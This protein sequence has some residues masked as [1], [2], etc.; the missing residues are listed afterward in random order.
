MNKELNPLILIQEIDTAIIKR[1]D[2]IELI[3][4]EISR[5]KAPL[6]EA[7]RKLKLERENLESI[8]KKKRE[9]DQGLKEIADK[10][11]NSKK[12]ASEIKTNKEY[13]AHLA[14]IESIESEKYLI[15]DDILFLMEEID[16]VRQSLKDAEAEVEK[17][18]KELQSIQKELEE[19][20]EDARKELAELKE[21]KALLAKGVSED[22]YSRYT[23]ALKKGAGLAVVEAADEVCLGCY[24]SIPPQLYLQVR[25]SDEII[26]CPQCDR[27]LFRKD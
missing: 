6:A 3:P 19:K 25:I 22:L 7:E 24:M 9:R 13:Q 8:E 21:K 4:G 20:C 27:L 1:G 10:V 14:E 26:Q 23:D 16:A 18:S 12:R 11:E 2:E 17:Q 15:E 5:Y